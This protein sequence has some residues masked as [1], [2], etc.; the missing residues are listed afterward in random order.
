M[1]VY[2]FVT[3]VESH[4]GKVKGRSHHFCAAGDLLFLPLLFLC[5]KSESKR[6]RRRQRST[7]SLVSGRVRSVSRH[8]D[9]VAPKRDG[10]GKGL[11]ENT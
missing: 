10:E 4:P 2:L 7:Q 1:Y 6:E 5:L 9:G 11:P 8:A 3:F